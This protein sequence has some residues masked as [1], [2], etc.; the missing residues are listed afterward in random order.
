[1]TKIKKF[2]IVGVVIIAI[3]IA[4]GGYFV[5]HKS[6]LAATAAPSVDSSPS[7][8]SAPQP[9]NPTVNPSS[10]ISL[11]QNFDTPS[12]GG[13][14]VGS[15]SGSN[16]AIQA[17]GTQGSPGQSNN[18]AAGSSQSNPF[19]PSTFGQYDKYKADKGALFGEVQAGN[20]KALGPNQKAAV[21]YRGWLTNGTMFDSSRAG[22]DGKL[23]PFIFTL[24]AHQ[25]IPGWEQALAGMKVGAVRLVI[26]PPSVGYGDKG[27]GS[28]PPGAVLVFQVQLADV[29]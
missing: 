4:V 8:A 28:I 14:S 27:Q 3:G 13:L 12:A 10:S 21:Y 20:G 1:M 29:Q 25:V 19:D 6:H 9:L 2:G 24:G 22:A 16:S 7:A 18:S 15:N 17:A 26:V 5:T 11:N 23:T